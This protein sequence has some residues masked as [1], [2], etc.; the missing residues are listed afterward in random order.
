MAVIGTPLDKAYPAEN[1]ALQIDD[2][3][4]SGGHFQ[5]AAAILRTLEMRVVLAVAAGQTMHDPVENPFGWNEQE[6]PDFEPE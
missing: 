4:T 5:S 3:T 6:C 2:V 1:K